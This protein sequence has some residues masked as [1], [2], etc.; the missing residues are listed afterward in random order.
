MSRSGLALANLVDKKIA[1]FYGLCRMLTG[2]NNFDD[3]QKHGKK[4]DHTKVD[5]LGKSCSLT[6]KK[7]NSSIIL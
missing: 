7:S 5:L 4:G 3:V 1:T 2:L 6:K